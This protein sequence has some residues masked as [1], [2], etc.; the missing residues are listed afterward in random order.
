MK[1]LPL[2]LKIILA[3]LGI[4]VTWVFIFFLENFKEYLD[5]ERLKDAWRNFKGIVDDPDA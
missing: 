2:I 5:I 3:G 1:P 4:Y